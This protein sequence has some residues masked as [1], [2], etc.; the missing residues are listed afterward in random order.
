M[1]SIIL[2]VR[3]LCLSSFL[4]PCS[5][6]G[7]GCDVVCGVCC[8]CCDVVCVVIANILHIAQLVCVGS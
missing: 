6:V 2:P 5:Y 1:Q 3:S 7:D 8:L 4:K